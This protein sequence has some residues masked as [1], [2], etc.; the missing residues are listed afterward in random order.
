V[1]TEIKIDWM[2][3]DPSAAARA[4]EPLQDPIEI[5]DN[6]LVIATWRGIHDQLSHEDFPP[7]AIVRHALEVVVG[8]RALCCDHRALLMIGRPP[9]SAT[10]V[11]IGSG[12][13]FGSPVVAGRTWTRF[14]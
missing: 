7:L 12:A 10:A 6:L 9:Q 1:S 2:R 14:E 5:G 13:V 8:E 4:Q 11:S 3:V